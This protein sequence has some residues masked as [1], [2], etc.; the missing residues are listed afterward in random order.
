MHCKIA[1]ISTCLDLVP[2][3][4]CGLRSSCRAPAGPRQRLQNTKDARSH[5]RELHEAPER[6]PRA[7]WGRFSALFGPPGAPKI[8]FSLKRY[9]EIVTFVFCPRRLHR[10][11][12]SARDLRSTLEAAL[13]AFRAR[14][15]CKLRAPSL[16]FFVFSCPWPLLSGLV[17]SVFCCFC[18]TLLRFCAPQFS[19][20]FVA[21]EVQFLLLF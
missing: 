10:H 2:A 20:P 19:W 17:W 9:S 21:T 15:G 16:L 14:F 13:K 5:S 3:S 18:S 6:P 1:N 4:S 12:S 11:L 7:T 8:S